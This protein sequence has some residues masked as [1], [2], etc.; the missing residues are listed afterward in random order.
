MCIIIGCTQLSVTLQGINTFQKEKKKKN[1]KDVRLITPC[2][3]T[4]QW[5]LDR[6]ETRRLSGKG[7]TTM[8]TL[9]KRSLA[10]SGC[11]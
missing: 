5:K 2:A 8:E 6:A 1:L 9:N 4:K 10:S 7:G 11:T 3:Q